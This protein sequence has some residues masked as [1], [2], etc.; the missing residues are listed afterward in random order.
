M[1]SIGLLRM[2]H[3]LDIINKVKFILFVPITPIVVALQLFLKYLIAFTV[4]IV[5]NDLWSIR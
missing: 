4:S 1:K 2:L 5:I 3:C